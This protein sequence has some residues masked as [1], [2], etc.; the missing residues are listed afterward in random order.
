MKNTSSILLVVQFFFVSVL[1]GTESD[2]NLTALTIQSVGQTEM[3]VPSMASKNPKKPNL[4]AIVGSKT[5]EDGVENAFIKTLSVDKNSEPK[6]VELVDESGTS[7]FSEATLRLESNR[8]YF[9]CHGSLC[10]V[11]SIFQNLKLENFDEDTKEAVSVLS[12]FNYL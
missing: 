3:E 9:V 10:W 5:G 7:Q 2:A 12:F 8:N 4:T 11:D 6:F 1:L